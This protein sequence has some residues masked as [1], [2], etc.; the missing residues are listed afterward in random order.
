M[1]TEERKEMEKRTRVVQETM[2]S[3]EIKWHS[4]N[5]KSNSSDFLVILS[6]FL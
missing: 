4:M 3:E 2:D 5:S 1:S 6:G